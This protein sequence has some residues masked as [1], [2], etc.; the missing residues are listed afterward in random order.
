M[1]QFL[2]R[3]WLWF[4][5]KVLRV[6]VH[7]CAICTR[8]Y[9]ANGHE[10]KCVEDISGE[11]TVRYTCPQCQK[12]IVENLRSIIDTISGFYPGA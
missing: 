6:T 7:R 1:A 8:D 3:L 5:D 10:G 12:I 4:N 9:V 2:I 11:R